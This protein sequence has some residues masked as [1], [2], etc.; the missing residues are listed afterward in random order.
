MLGLFFW[1]CW[2][3]LL[4]WNHSWL[5]RKR[6]CCWYWLFLYSY[7]CLLFV[8]DYSLLLSRN[9]WLCW[10]R[11]YRFWCRL[12]DWCSSC[13]CLCTWYRNYW[14]H[15]LRSS[16]LRLFYFCNCWCCKWSR[17]LLFLF[18]YCFNFWTVFLFIYSFYLF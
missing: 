10:Y 16:W 14:Y 1:H 17:L 5:C 11:Y 3:W 12:S 2:N 7:L 9:Y 13:W 18:D 6:L 8:W 15:R 4:W